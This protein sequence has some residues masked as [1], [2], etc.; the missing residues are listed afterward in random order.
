MV[1]GDQA[2]RQAALPGAL[3]SPFD[4]EALGLERPVRHCPGREDVSPVVEHQHRAVGVAA[5]EVAA[6]LADLRGPERRVLDE[7]E[8]VEVPGTVPSASFSVSTSTR[9]L[10]RTSVPERRHRLVAVE[11]D[12]VAVE[13]RLLE[14]PLDVGRRHV[15]LDE[16]DHHLAAVLV[17]ELPIR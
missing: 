10:R 14:D 16:E 8:A 12:H 6:E 5:L 13:P 4:Q 7:G 11:G 2:H 15:R 1:D 3:V 17:E 9:R